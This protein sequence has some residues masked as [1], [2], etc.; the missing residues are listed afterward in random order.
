MTPSHIKTSEVKVGGFYLPANTNWPYVREVTYMLDDFVTYNDYA[1]ETGEPGFANKGCTKKRF[2]AW[3]SR[4]L[5]EDE[6]SRLRTADGHTQAYEEAARAFIASP[7]GLKKVAFWLALAVRNEIEDF[8]AC[9]SELTIKNTDRYMP[10]FNRSVRNAIYTGLYSLINYGRET[11]SKNY[12]DFIAD[13]PDYWEEPE[14]LLK[15]S[16]SS[17]SDDE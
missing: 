10:E 6:V 5:S 14:L 1:Y 4:R 11:W 17:I 8:H 16:E 9:D 2:A 7:D 3:A 13:I 15:Y 12:A